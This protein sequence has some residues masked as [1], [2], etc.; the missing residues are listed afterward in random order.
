MPTSPTVIHLLL[1]AHSPFTITYLKTLSLA[2]DMYLKLWSRPSDAPLCHLCYQ[3]E[4]SPSAQISLEK[5]LKDSVS[6]YSFYA[7]PSMTLFFHNMWTWA[8]CIYIKK[9]YFIYVMHI[10]K[11]HTVTLCWKMQNQNDDN[12]FQHFIINCFITSTTIHS[13]D[14]KTWMING[15]EYM[16]IKFQKHIGL[17]LFSLRTYICWL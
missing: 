13:R 6:W 12:Y 8:Q 9:E 1:T 15:K 11:H 3:Q 14:Y 10:Q 17:K 2:F 16:S 7:F 5:S 4:C